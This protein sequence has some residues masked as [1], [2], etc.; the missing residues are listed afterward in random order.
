MKASVKKTVL[1]TVFSERVAEMFSCA[2][3]AASE[4]EVLA[5]TNVLH[6]DKIWR[7]SSAG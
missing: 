1:R 6:S 4:S 7:I 5:K 2:H 3:A